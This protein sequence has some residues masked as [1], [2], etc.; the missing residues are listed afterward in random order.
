[1]SGGSRGAIAQ[2]MFAV[3]LPDHMTTFARVS[4]FLPLA[5]LF[6]SGQ[7]ALAAQCPANSHPEVVAIPGNLRTA[8]CWCNSG[9]VNAGGVCVRVAPAPP[10]PRPNGAAAPEEGQSEPGR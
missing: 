2:R 4:L 3:S 8:H 7:G 9:F 6:A 5:Y 1:M 10:T